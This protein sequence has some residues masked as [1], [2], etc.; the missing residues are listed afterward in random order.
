MTVPAESMVSADVTI[1]RWITEAIEAG[2]PIR[3]SSLADKSY[4]MYNVNGVWGGATVTLQGSWDVDNVPPGQNTWVTL[5]ESDN[6]ATCSL[7]ANGAGVILENP[8]W[9]R[10]NRTAAAGP[11][12]HVVLVGTGR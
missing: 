6:S 12:I 9:I 3:A 8:I 11:A 10:P 4:G 5:N 7:T 2:E 1:I